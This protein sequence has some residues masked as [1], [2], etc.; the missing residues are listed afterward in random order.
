MSFGTEDESGDL[1]KYC[2]KHGN[3]TLEEDGL[4]CV[5]TKEQNISRY[6][7]DIK[8]NRKGYVSSRETKHPGKDRLGPTKNI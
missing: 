3:L 5:V 6:K 7:E 4:L 8:K 1:T 2:E